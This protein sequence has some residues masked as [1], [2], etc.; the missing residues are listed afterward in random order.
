MSSA[1]HI[2]ELMTFSKLKGSLEGARK[3]AEEKE[4]RLQLALSWAKH[5]DVLSVVRRE[6]RAG[7]L[8]R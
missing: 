1:A 2:K 6:A 7:I 4:R 5:C 3:H 8:E